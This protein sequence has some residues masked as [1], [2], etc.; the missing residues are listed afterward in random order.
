MKARTKYLMA[1]YLRL[2]ATVRSSRSALPLVVFV[3]ITALIFWPGSNSAA[4]AQGNERAPSVKFHADPLELETKRAGEQPS[5]VIVRN[6]DGTGFGFAAEVVD[7]RGVLGTP[8]PPSLSLLGDPLEIEFEE[9]KN[10]ASE[11]AILRNGSGIPT[12]VEFATALKDSDGVVQSVKPQT[13]R[14]EPYEVKPV[15]LTFEAKDLSEAVEGI[16]VAKASGG[17]ERIASG[18]LPLTL[19]PEP[20]ARTATLKDPYNLSLVLPFLISG[21]VVFGSYFAY[22]E[23]FR[24]CRQNERAYIPLF[25]RKSEFGTGLGVDFSKSWATIIATV[26]ALLTAFRGAEIFPE[27]RQG[28]TEDEI[29]T[30]ALVVGGLLFIAPAVYNVIRRRKPSIPEALLREIEQEE[31]KKSPLP[32]APVLNKEFELA[33]YLFPLLL[34]SAIVLGTL[35]GQLLIVWF[36]I[37]EIEPAAISVLGRTLLRIVTIAGALYAT[38]YVVSGIFSNLNE[39][40]RW[41]KDLDEWEAS[42][43]K[44]EKIPLTLPRRLTLF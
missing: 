16:L 40:V 18:T 9:G 27:A 31:R 23:H 25:W 19:K 3:L 12:D 30:L 38:V 11:K 43:R 6:G 28:F 29:A 13:I 36:L 35:L 17:E 32:K 10:E 34:A 21:V 15:E 24:R 26:A 8:D 14:L 2:P 44:S 39:K 20:K 42:Q 37:T 22:L 1:A 4:W 41:E 33:G 5:E 7:A